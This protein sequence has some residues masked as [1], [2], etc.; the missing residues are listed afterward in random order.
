MSR[1]SKQSEHAPPPPPNAFAGGDVGAAATAAA[2]RGRVF[3]AHVVAFV[4]KEPPGW[5]LNG[6]REATGRH[7]VAQTERVEQGIRYRVCD[8]RVLAT[9]MGTRFEH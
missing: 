1:T 6:E 8:Q 2:K 9:A 7:H 3:L 4:R 5:A